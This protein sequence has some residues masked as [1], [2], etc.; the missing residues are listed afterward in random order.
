MALAGIVYAPMESW[1][2]GAFLGPIFSLL[3]FG[4]FALGIKWL[5]A[6]YMVDGR[7]KRALLAERIKSKYSHSNW[8]ILRQAARHPRGKP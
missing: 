3:L 4:V 7:L 5:I 2:F 8:R 1:Y 6:T